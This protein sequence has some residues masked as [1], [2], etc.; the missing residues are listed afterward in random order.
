MA[1]SWDGPMPKVHIKVVFDLDW[2]ADHPI[3]GDLGHKDFQHAV[4]G[5][6]FRVKG[7]IEQSLLQEIE[8]YDIKV[9]CITVRFRVLEP[10]TQALMRAALARLWDT[11]KLYSVIDVS[12]HINGRALAIA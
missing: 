2:P 3:V 4:G 1:P 8:L 9:G 11:R 12:G 5:T 6:I 7:L 10:V